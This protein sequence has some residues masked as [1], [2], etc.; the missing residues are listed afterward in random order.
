M[1]T[2]AEALAAAATRLNAAGVDS[3]RLDARALLAHIL[4]VE[5]TTLFSRPERRLSADEVVRYESAVARRERRE[6]LS[7]IT[8]WREFWS[9][10]FRVTAD[11]LDPRADTET[12]VEAVLELVPD[13]KLPLRLLD[14][15]TGTGC[16]LLSL[17][18]EMPNASGVGVD[19]SEAACAVAR[20]N[21]RRLGL[22]QR[23]SIVLGDWGSGLDGC[24]DVIVSNP[25]YIP[26]AETAALQPEVAQFEPRAALAAGD[27]GLACYR[28]IAPQLPRLLASGGN[29]VF[30]VGR[31]QAAAV[32]GMLAAAGLGVTGTRRDLAGVDRCVL[33]RSV[34][35]CAA[36][37]KNVGNDPV[38]D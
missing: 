6:P 20:D 22:D 31:G 12:V 30:E 38:P 29:V 5:T 7:H 2:V 36:A 17:L 14:L 19:T 28:I 18:H 3:A 34:A 23:V 21:A 35:Q 11:T 8:G 25:P 9:L 10:P 24:F 37:K 1:T 16:I 26:V 4:A 32:A 33:A 15:G 27:D 13:R